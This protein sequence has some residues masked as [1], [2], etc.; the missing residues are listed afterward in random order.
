MLIASGIGTEINLF[1]SFR[2]HIEALFEYPE[3]LIACGDVPVPELGVEN[4]LLLG[5]PEVVRL[6][7]SIALVGEEGVLF[8]RFRDGGIGI[9]GSFLFRTMLLDGRRR[10]PGLP[11]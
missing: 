10:G 9:E 6:I 5:P 3:L 4:K 1:H 11:S 8:L 2:E 7:R